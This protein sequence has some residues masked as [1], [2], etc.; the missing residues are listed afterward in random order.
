MINALPIRF[1]AWGRLSSPDRKQMTGIEIGLKA[2]GLASSS[3]PGDEFG[4]IGMSLEYATN[5]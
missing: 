1:T 4:A 2:P 3:I 5:A